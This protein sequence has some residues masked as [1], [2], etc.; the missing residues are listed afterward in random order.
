MPQYNQINETMKKKIPHFAVMAEYRLWN[1]YLKEYHQDM[2]F[3]IL[4]GNDTKTDYEKNLSD[5]RILQEKVR[6]FPNYEE[7]LQQPFP[8]QDRNEMLN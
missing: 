2:K 4:W 3:D 8:L 5:L 1:S 6:A 7:Y